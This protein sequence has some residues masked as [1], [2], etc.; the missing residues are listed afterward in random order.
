MSAVISDER[1]W[2]HKTVT[3]L[4][5]PLQ[6]SDESHLEDD[7]ANPRRRDDDDD[8][9]GELVARE[10]RRALRDQASANGSNAT[11][12][13]DTL[14]RDI[15]IFAIL[16]GMM[17]QTGAA[18]YWAG[19]VSKGQESA[20]ETIKAIQDEQAYTRAQLQVIDG[21]LQKIEGR[22]AERE[23]LKGR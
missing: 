11:R 15:G 19:N 5:N 10:I 18:F 4:L 21:K 13:V 17:V 23:R 8:D 16:L 12:S 9:I 22:E 2:P 20:K 14:R 3:G 7:M 6:N 1:N